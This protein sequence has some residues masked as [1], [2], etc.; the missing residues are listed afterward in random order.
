MM[1]SIVVAAALLAVPACGGDPEE[2]PVEEIVYEP[3]VDPGTSEQFLGYDVMPEVELTIAA[4]DVASLEAEPRTYVKAMI[5]YRGQTFGPV[6][7]RCKGQNSF[8]PFSEKPSL[9]INVDEYVENVSFYGLKDLTFNNMSS[10]LSMM[11]ERLAYLVAR[12]AG[13]PASRANHALL[14]VNGEAYGLYTNLETVKKRALSNWFDDNDGPLFKATDVDFTAEL[15]GRY[16]L[17]S[18]PDDRSLLEGLAAALTIADPD[19]AM[20]AAAQYVDI[21]HLQ[22]F[23]AMEAVIAQ[24]DAFP[25]SFPGDDYM[26]Y[27]DPTSNKLWFIPGGMDETFLSGEFPVMQT[28]SVLAARCKESPACYQGLVDQI[29]EILALTEAID[30][31]GEKARVQEAITPHIEADSRKPYDATMIADG[32]MQLYYFIHGR[33]ELLTAMLPPPTP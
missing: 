12:E 14:T 3:W 32:Q 6:G 23:W 7:V 5:T 15:V 26:L 9:R 4:E 30:L 22:R 19:Q 28:Q 13:L 18:G 29:W 33:R 21:A 8:L 2:P 1:R 16:Q 10:D 20:A 27:A 11:H 24:F 31:E 25:Y 17:D